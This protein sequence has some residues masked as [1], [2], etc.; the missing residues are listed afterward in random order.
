MS[1]LR[2]FDYEYDGVVLKGQLALPAGKGPHPG[3]LVMHDAR[4]LGALTRRRA[5]DL[6]K[7]GYA[8]LAT[9]MYGN[10][11]TLPDP[12]EESEFMM[13]V[14]GNAALVRGRVNAALKALAALPE[15]DAARMGAIGFCFGG[16]C[17]L[18]LARSGANAR[19]VVSF[20]GLLHTLEPARAGEVKAHMLVL[21]GARDPYAPPEHVAALQAE[22]NAANAQCDVTSYGDGYH[23]FTDA[24]AEHQLTNTPGIKY[25]PLIDKLSWAQCTAFLES[26]VK[27]A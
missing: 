22:M 3:V 8:A 26:V 4:G 27:G 23:A 11:R 24:S 18:E 2:A 6:A 13:S 17:V 21:T 15:V 20:H 16:H 1:E 19:G 14:L 9:D 10:A 25:D 12:Q 7:L 5:V